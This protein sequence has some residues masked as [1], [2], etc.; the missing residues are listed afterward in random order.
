[1]ASI[2]VV[3]LAF[4]AGR[5]PGPQTVDD[6]VNAIAET[7]KCPT[8]QGESVADSNAPSSREIRSDIAQRVAEGQSGDEIRNYYAESFGPEYLLTPASSGVA[9]LVW[10]LPVVAMGAGAAGLYLAFRRW[11]TSPTR[12]ATDDDRAL[13]AEARHRFESGPD[14]P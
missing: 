11:R 4:A 8:C 6:R 10:V 5:E 13:V 7:I 3:A 14:E 9:S 2:L 1:M 12:S